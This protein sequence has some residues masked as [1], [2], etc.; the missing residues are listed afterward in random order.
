MSAEG[1][2]GATA[3]EHVVLQMGGTNATAPASSTPAT[4]THLAPS[5]GSAVQAAPDGLAPDAVAPEQV[6]IQVLAP[7]QH[8]APQQDPMD[9]VPTAGSE[10]TFLPAGSVPTAGAG[11]STVQPALPATAQPAPH[12]AVD[13]GASTSAAAGGASGGDDGLA[14][15]PSGGSGG[16]PECRICLLSERPDDLVAPCR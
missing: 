7:V 10:P 13:G 3:T 16:C 9:A 12:T 6:S 15:E 14:P 11:S 5:H 1:H 8:I 4:R 2:G